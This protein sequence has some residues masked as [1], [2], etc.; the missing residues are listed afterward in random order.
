LYV[1]STNLTRLAFR[2]QTNCFCAK[3]I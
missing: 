3:W 2:Q 1:A